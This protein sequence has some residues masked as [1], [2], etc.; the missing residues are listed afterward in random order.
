MIPVNILNVL[1]I[2]PRRKIIRRNKGL[3]IPS[4]RECIKHRHIAKTPV[5]S[6]HIKNTAENFDTK[7]FI[8]EVPD[9]IILVYTLLLSSVMTVCAANTPLN[10]NP[11]VIIAKA[12]PICTLLLV[13]FGVSSISSLPARSVTF[14]SGIFSDISFRISI[15]FDTSL[16]RQRSNH[17][18][19]QSQN[20]YLCKVSLLHDH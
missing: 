4:S 9:I 3:D 13:C 2:I 7:Y 5:C 10:I 1:N 17:S 12:Y 15:V 16:C 6:R 19:Q 8:V 18:S 20:H 14:F 11:R